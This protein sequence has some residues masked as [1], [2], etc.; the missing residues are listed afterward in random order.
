[1]SSQPEPRGIPCS[2]CRP[3]LHYH[4][5]EM[6]KSIA[7]LGARGGL[8]S[9][10]VGEALTRGHRVRA[11]VR[12][13]ERYSAPE[14]VTV[15]AAD[16]SRAQEVATA[17]DGVD[18]CFFCVNPP[19]ARWLDLFPPLLEAVI[20]GARAAGSRLVFPGN[21]WI[22]GQGEP[23]V[24]LDEDRSPA[25]ISLRGSLR[26][27]MEAQ[28]SSSDVPSMIVRL[29]EFYGPGVVTLTARVLQSALL[30]KRALWPGPLDLPIELVFMPDAART[31]VALGCRDELPAE[32][33]HLP[34]SR[35]TAREFA[36]LAC[37]AAGTKARL[38]A[39]PRGVLRL[40]GLFDGTAAGAADISHLWSHPVLLDGSRCRALLGEVPC[41][42]LSVGVR[43]TVDWMRSAGALKLQG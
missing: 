8:G 30:G 13:P 20:E 1:M 32:L 43:E 21:V 31:M 42:E 17:L 40:A 41:T 35:T 11:V 34:G 15:A 29:P 27:E 25:P 37:S 3:T 12:D 39:V 5:S 36:E 38:T 9:N 19:F 28:L 10:I 7:I 6:V 22:Y 26:A 18:V 23:G 33:V 24:E 14:G 4:A 2:L 16:A